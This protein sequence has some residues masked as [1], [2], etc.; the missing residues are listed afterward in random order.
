MTATHRRFVYNGWSLWQFLFKPDPRKARPVQILSN[1]FGVAFRQKI[2][3]F[4]L[5]DLS[6]YSGGSFYFENVALALLMCKPFLKSTIKWFFPL[7]QQ[8]GDSGFTWYFGFI[9]VAI[10]T[11]PQ[12]YKRYPCCWVSVCFPHFFW[13]SL[14]STTYYVAW[15][16]LAIGTKSIM[17]TNP[18]HVSL[19]DFFLNH[20]SGGGSCSGQSFGLLCYE[21]GTSRDLCYLGPA[22]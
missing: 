7:L 18:W 8:N 16:T 22:R 14:G 17:P 9:L 13:R 1:F 20:E 12:S 2:S 4:R 10:D 5:G 3:E 11:A 15:F 6:E 19:R 21:H